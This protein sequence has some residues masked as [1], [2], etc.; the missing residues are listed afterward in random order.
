MNK[1]ILSLL[2]NIGWIKRQALKLGGYAGTAVTAWL[3]GKLA[4]LHQSGI[5]TDEQTATISQG[6]GAL[7][8][9]IATAVVIAA[10]AT[11]SYFAKSRRE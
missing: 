5:V 4:T 2:G 11:A 3:L 10:E 9:G 8:V 6:I 7:E 1:I